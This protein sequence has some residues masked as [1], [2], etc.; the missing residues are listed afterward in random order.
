[1]VKQAP[2]DTLWRPLRRLNGH[3]YIMILH[4]PEVVQCAPLFIYTFPL[5]LPHHLLEA[6]KF[7]IRYP[8]PAKITKMSDK[9]R[10]YRYKKGLMQREVA[11]YLGIDRSTYIHYEEQDHDYYPIAE[12]EKLASLHGVQVTDFLDDYN[13]FL[14]RDQ[15]RQIRE[16][17][18]ALHMTQ[19]EYAKQLGVPVGNL[20]K[21][22]KNRVR[23]L[24]STWERCF[25]DEK[26]GD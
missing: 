2:S 24:K 18:L 22:E 11:D 21:W 6:E 5:F 25:K 3:A 4:T 15:G 16:R 9:L 10:Y 12:V 7:N 17:R 20:K 14:Y 19:T 8:D 1:M 23:M 13:L 26:A